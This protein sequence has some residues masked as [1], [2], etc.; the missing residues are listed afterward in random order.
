MA[1]TLTNFSKLIDTNFPIKGQD[2]VGSN[3]FNNNFNKIKSSFNILTN[4]VSQLQNQL[5]NLSES[6]NFGNGTIF[7]AVFS[8]SSKT[9]NDIGL[10][11][12]GRVD[13]N[14]NLGTYHKVFSENANLTFNISNWPLTNRFAKIRLEIKNNNP[15][16]TSTVY[17]NF[18]GN[19]RYLGTLINNIEL[20]SNQSCF[21]DV[22]T[23]NSGNTINIKPLGIVNSMLVSSGGGSSP[24]LTLPTITSVAPASIPYDGNIPITIYGTN[25]GGSPIVLING[26]TVGTITAS[27]STQITFYS[28]LGTPGTYQTVKVRTDQGDSNSKSYYLYDQAYPLDGGGN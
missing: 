19:T 7:S 14:F 1:S 5:I 22:W 18:S 9:L 11:S 26:T 8:N 25:F 12:T 3:G 27:S 4:E 21:F 10:V 28:I 6:N 2:S 17:I 23:I 24:S 20:P 15:S 13:I 16:N